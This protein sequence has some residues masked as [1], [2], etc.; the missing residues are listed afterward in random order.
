MKEQDNKRKLPYDDGEFKHK[1]EEL[2]VTPHSCESDGM[3]Y[4]SYPPQWRCK[5]CEKF[6]YIHKAT[7]KPFIPPH[8]K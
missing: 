1:Y 3:V 8:L 2:K 4:T 6:E 5:I 7:M